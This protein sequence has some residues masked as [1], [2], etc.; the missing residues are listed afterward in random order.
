M[1]EFNRRLKAQRSRA[2]KTQAQ[3]AAVLSVSTKHYA[4]M[5]NG[6]RAF[7]LQYLPKL[8]SFYNVSADYFLGL[9]DF[10]YPPGDI[11][12]GACIN[13]KFFAMDDNGKLKVNEMIDIIYRGED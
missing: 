13:P 4:N 1:E 7:P 2:G 10:P 5:E 3:I 12:G 11:N 6:K 9:D 8:C